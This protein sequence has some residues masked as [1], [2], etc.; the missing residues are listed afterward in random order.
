LENDVDEVWK[1]ISSASVPLPLSPWLFP[2]FPLAWES[3][4]AMAMGCLLALQLG[5]LSFTTDYNY[6]G[7]IK[8]HELVPGGADR[9][10]RHN[11]PG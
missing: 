6:D 5:D 9:A 7:E 1:G 8:T 2:L 3:L 10:V 11:A 4:G